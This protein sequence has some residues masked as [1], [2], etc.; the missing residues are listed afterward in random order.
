MFSCEHRLST[1]HSS[2]HE[3]CIGDSIDG[4]IAVDPNACACVTIR[5]VNASVGF[6]PNIQDDLTNK[7]NAM[8]TELAYL[9]GKAAAYGAVTAL[10]INI[11]F[12]VIKEMGAN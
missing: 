2:H 1:E 8:T 7:V 10:I 12:V 5:V 11:A 6:C 3:P 9:K 4:E